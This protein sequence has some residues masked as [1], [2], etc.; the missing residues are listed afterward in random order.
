MSLDTSRYFKNFSKIEVDMTIIFDN[1][2]GIFGNREQKI[3]KIS[4][5][6]LY[7]VSCDEHENGF[8]MP[9]DKN[10]NVDRYNG[11][12]VVR[13]GKPITVNFE[14]KEA[15]RLMQLELREK[16]SIMGYWDKNCIMFV[17]SK[18]DF[19]IIIEKFMKNLS[20][21]EYIIKESIDNDECFKGLMLK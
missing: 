10:V 17:T 1:E 16:Q 11:F 4:A 12:S 7:S 6:R 13:I 20:K 14:S 2:E 15:Q 21:V 8:S 3:Q 19:F 5:I 18:K 9:E